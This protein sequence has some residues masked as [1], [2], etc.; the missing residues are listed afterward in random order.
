M[1][2]KGREVVL[3]VGG[4]ISAYKSAE[5]LRRLQDI[6]LIVTVV[7][8]AASLNF[9]GKA[10]WEALSG[11]EV[12]TDLWANPKDVPHISLAKKTSAI[13]IAP[14]TADLLAKL[15]QGICDDLLTNLV[16][17]SDSPKILVPAMHPEMWLNP[18]TQENVSTLRNRGFL[19]IEPDE[20]KMTGEDSGIGRYPE[21]KRLI[22]E[23]S[24]FLEIKSDLNGIKILVSAGGTREAIDPV[25]FIG[26]KSSGK[27]GIAIAEA[28]AR[29]GAQVVLI[30]AN[31]SD[32]IPEGIKYIPVTSTAEMLSNLKDEFGNCQVLIM[33]A[34]VADARPSGVS[35]RKIKKN[36]FLKIELEKNK[37]ILKE[38]SQFRH[39]K[40]IM[41][42][43]SAETGDSSHE[44]AIRKL[45]EKELD[46][47]YTNDVTSGKIFG[48]DETEG[49]I[50][51]KGGHKEFFPLASKKTLADLLLDKV[52]NK[53][54]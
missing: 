12:I 44:E 53:L 54:G 39:Q 5:L 49:W 2:L 14:T 8:T 47:L 35:E 11:R 10:T 18:A 42:G 51:S 9:V 4:G 37:D 6:G 41:V 31:I 50:L 36:E 33:A 24:Q 28:A 52:K 3:G 7:P 38:L 25:R 15:V 27:Q 19:V 34:A 13:I 48:S 30:G 46:F 43:F 17:A 22:D 21:I 29:R 45:N 40:Q 1:T 32:N 16:M 20:G 26:N 23:I